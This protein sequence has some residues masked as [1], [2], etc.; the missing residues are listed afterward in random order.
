MSEISNN[1]DYLVACTITTIFNTTP[2]LMNEEYVQELIGKVYNISYK[3][4]IEAN[5]FTMKGDEILPRKA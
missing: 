4:K 1:N 3:T 2:L 5:L